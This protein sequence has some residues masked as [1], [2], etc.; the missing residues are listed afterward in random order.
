MTQYLTQ[1]SFTA[2]G[3]YDLKDL[4]DQICKLLSQHP[5]IQVGCVF[6]AEINRGVAT[7]YPEY[8]REDDDK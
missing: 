7:E 8:N 6:T 2:V 5:D 4:N 1:V 3:K